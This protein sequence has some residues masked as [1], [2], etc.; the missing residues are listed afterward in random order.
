MK[1]YTITLSEADLQTLDRA[2]GDLPKRA[3]DG[4]VA[5]VGPC[6]Q[7]INQQVQAANAAQPEMPERP[8]SN[9]HAAPS[10]DASAP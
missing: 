4:F 5:A 10:A 3:W 7:N 1:T 6:L 2:I 8:Q 9:G